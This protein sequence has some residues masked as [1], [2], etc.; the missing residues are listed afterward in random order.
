[1]E[2]ILN[3]ASHPAF[4]LCTVLWRLSLNRECTLQNRLLVINSL[5]DGHRRFLEMRLCS[6]RPASLEAV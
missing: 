5:H 6:V 3:F 4:D 2:L 1:M